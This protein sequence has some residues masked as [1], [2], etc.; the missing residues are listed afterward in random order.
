MEDIGVS[1]RRSDARGLIDHAMKGG[2]AGSGNKVPSRPSVALATQI[3]YDSSLPQQDILALEWGQ[4]DG[5]SLTATQIKARGDHV[6][7][8]IPL[9]AKTITMLNDTPRRSTHIIISE[10]TG[11]PYTDRRVFS[12]IFRKFR[13]RVGVEGRTFHDLRRTALT[14][15]GSHGATNA[16]IV[17]R[18]GHNINSRVLG[19]YVK[20]DR[21]TAMNAAKKRWGMADE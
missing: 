9:S 17:S 15:L 21:A 12:R 4:F 18:S 13:N 2:V 19:D 11:K 3:A 5:N 10:D 8:W 6:E 7:L 14:E 20:P 16:E 1:R